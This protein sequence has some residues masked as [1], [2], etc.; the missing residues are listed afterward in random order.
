MNEI[1]VKLGP[2]ALLLA[3]ISICMATLAI[4]TF[5]TSRADMSLAEK[6]ADT[7]KERYE[8]EVMGQQYLAETSDELNQGMVFITDADGMAH[9][10]IESGNA[11]LDIA[12]KPKGADGY[13]VGKWTITRNWEEDTGMGNLWDGF[14]N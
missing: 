1:P 14:W 9:H 4:L 12:L 10:T 5:S 6:Y 11:T 3:V 13:I 8:L 2:L 7:V